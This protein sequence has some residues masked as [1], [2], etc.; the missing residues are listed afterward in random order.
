M[1]ARDVIMIAILLFGFGMAFFVT[2]LVFNTM[3]NAMLNITEINASNATVSVFEG[4]KNTTER[5]DYVVFG[6]FIALIL[7]LIITGW[8]IGGHPIFMFIY[9][10]FI[11]MG[12]IISSIMSNVWETISQSSVFGLTITSFPIT[13]N[14]LL[15]LPIY[16]AIIGFIG[17]VIMF[18]KPLSESY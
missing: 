5:L 16:I 15:N 8:F 1:A 7:G 17:I 18:A 11:V 12:V 10:V 9:F 14:I 2:H 3:T 6:V 13:N 4:V